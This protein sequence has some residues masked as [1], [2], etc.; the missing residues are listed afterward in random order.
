[1]ETLV[2]LHDKLL[3]YDEQRITRNHLLNID[4]IK[5]DFVE[6]YKK[7]PNNYF[8]I[9]LDKYLEFIEDYKRIKK[10]VQLSIDF[11][12]KRKP[13]RVIFNPRLSEELS[14]TSI[15]QQVNSTQQ[16]LS[17]TVQIFDVEFYLALYVHFILT[18][19][20]PLALP[21]TM[22]AFDFNIGF[23]LD[24]L[25][26]SSAVKV[27]EFLSSIETYH[28]SL[29][30]SGKEQLI[31]F[32]IRSK[33]KGE[34]K[35]RLGKCTATSLVDLKSALFQRVLAKETTEQLARKVKTAVQGKRTLVEYARYL[36][37]LTTRMAAATIRETP[38]LHV[39]TTEQN[40]AKFALAQFK[41]NCHEQYH[42]VLAAARPKTLEE[43]VSIASSAPIQHHREVFFTTRNY[44]QG[45]RGNNYR[46]FNNQQNARS[47]RNFSGQRHF[48][49]Q[50]NTNFNNSQHFGNGQHNNGQR[51]NNS[52]HTRNNNYN[53]R[54]NYNQRSNGNNYN[55]R[56]NQ[57]RN[58]NQNVNALT[59]ATSTQQN[60]Q[61]NIQ[62]QSQ[63]NMHVMGN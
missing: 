55:Q 45:Q 36:E 40:C 29:S 28:D 57:N 9:Y 35:T 12:T 10:S 42:D 59:E 22:A 7:L 27:D 3:K 16:F 15:H 60:G 39:E 33:I 32:L 49:G 30:N 53:G 41:D 5:T 63:Q 6:I 48:S 52:Y 56:N 26:S 43:A 37:D 11:S 24:E 18:R 19:P 58:Q 13:Q 50:R 23:K 20:R 62:N 47:Q 51:G 46:K 17:P 44:Q 38:T 34:A 61:Q 8:K 4:L 1:M 2:K 14:R 25:S 54:N 31:K 21:S